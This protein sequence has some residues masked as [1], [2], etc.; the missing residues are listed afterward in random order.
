MDGHNCLKTEYGKQKTF[1]DNLMRLIEEGSDLRE[2]LT[3]NGLAYVRDNLD[4]ANIAPMLE[5]ALLEE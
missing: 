2:Y 4:W 5:K 1:C 3:L